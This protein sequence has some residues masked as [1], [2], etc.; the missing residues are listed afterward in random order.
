MRGLSP[1]IAGC[2]VMLAVTAHADTPRT[3]PS[4]IEIDR[5]ASPAGRIGFA[6][7]GG[8]PV[9]AWGVSVA[10]SWLEAPIRIDSGAFGAGTPASEPVRRRETLALGGAIALGDSVVFDAAVRGSHQIGAR[11][12]AAGQP[13]RLARF[14]VHDVR[15]GARVRVAGNRASAALL[16][17]D[18]TLPT[19]EDGHFAGD[20]RWTAAWRL[21]GR[22]TLS[23]D[24]VLAATAGVRLHGA[25][26]VV[27]NRLVGDEL[28]GA[29]GVALPLTV[30]GLSGA[31]ARVTATAE[32]AGALGDDIGVL[33][34]PSP[35]EARVG[36]LVRLAPALT[37][38]VRAG[39]A[40]VDEIGAPRVRGVVELAWAPIRDAP[41]RSAEPV[42]DEPDE[43][44]DE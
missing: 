12:R 43:P 28:F 24:V 44:T 6:F 10:A 25:E 3:T 37:I 19:G 9:D 36:A 23:G 5:D 15:L 33:S 34:A 35:I 29:A 20:A 30:L 11:L 13:E 16:R 41:P 39:A 31:A 14:V 22:A 1:A 32:L 40:L 4:R 26:V 17:G 7:D 8:E 27:G 2:A 18:L 42:D 21:I 38:G